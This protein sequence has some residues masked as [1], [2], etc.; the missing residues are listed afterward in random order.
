MAES[1]FKV[2]EG[3]LI[4]AGFSKWAG[5]YISAGGNSPLLTNIGTMNLVGSGNKEIDGGDFLYCGILR[6]PP[7]HSVSRNLYD[8]DAT[9]TYDIQSDSGMGSN[10]EIDNYGTFKKSAGTGTSTIFANS[11]PEDFYFNHL[12]GTVEADT[13]TS[14]AEQL[15]RQHRRQF[16]CRGWRSD[17][18]KQR[19]IFAGN[20]SGTYTGSGDGE[21]QMNSGA[22][23][24]VRPGATL[25]SRRFI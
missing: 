12:G 23:T 20:Y 18:S 17:G 21:L 22:I 4:S 5:G 25:T 7:N 10:G 9:G 19:S 2:P 11:D 8:N 24:I 14:E 13:G 15:P 16:Y 1:K 6:S 3:R